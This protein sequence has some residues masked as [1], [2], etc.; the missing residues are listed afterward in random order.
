MKIVL[1]CGSE[2]NQQALAHKI[3]QEFPLAGIVIEKR[4]A[5]RKLTL[6]KIFVKLTEKIFIPS[7]GHA[8]KNLMEEY[9]KSYKG[10]PSTKMITVE[11]INSDEAFRFTEQLQPDLVLVSGTRLVKAKMLSLH[12]RI[13]ILNLHTGLSPYIKGGPNCTNWCLATKQF[14]LIGNTVMWIDKGIDSGNILTSEFTPLTGEESLAQLHLKVM[15]HAHDLY[16]RAVKFLGE[17]KNQS[18]PQKEIAEGKTFYTREWTLSQKMNAV[19]NFKS[20]PEL[21]QNG[22]AETERK[23]GSYA[24]INLP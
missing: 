2:P 21:F 10:F 1:W 3:H 19:K 17:G 24:E 7:L 22:K 13:G 23:K 4:A 11:N 20:F 5:S 12:P 9:R 18:V 15:N 8:W 14:H 6:K 16:V